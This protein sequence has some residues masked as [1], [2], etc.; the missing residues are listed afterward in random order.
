MVLLRPFLYCDGLVLKTLE[1]GQLRNRPSEEY[2]K[3]IQQ[4]LDKHLPLNSDGDL[5]M[6]ERR[7]DQISHFVLRLVYCLTEESRRWFLQQEHALFKYA[8]PT[9]SIHATHCTCFMWAIK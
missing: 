6:E 1:V 4:A 8:L 5:I 2:K 9:L 3:D 7:K